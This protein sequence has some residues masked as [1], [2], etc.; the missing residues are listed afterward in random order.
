MK[1][2]TKR[3]KKQKTVNSIKEKN[4]TFSVLEHR[5]VSLPITLSFLTLKASASI[6]RTLVQHPQKLAISIKIPQKTAPCKLVHAA[7]LM[8]APHSFLASIAAFVCII[9]SSLKTTLQPWV[10]LQAFGGTLLFKENKMININT[11]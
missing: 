8:S 2:C 7:I 5:P 11:N 4:I 1:M 10:W 9:V 6:K 3:D